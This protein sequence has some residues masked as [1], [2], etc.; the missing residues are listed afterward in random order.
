MMHIIFDRQDDVA[1]WVFEQNGD[2]FSLTSG[3]ATMGF[4][5]DNQLIAGAVYHGF[6]QCDIIIS[7]SSV[8]PKWCNKQNLYAIFAYPFEQLGCARL[9]AIVAKK[10]KRSRKLV[11]GLGF[12]RE[13]CLKKGYNGRQDAIVYGMLAENCKWL[14][15]KD[16]THERRTRAGS[17]RP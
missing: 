6:R 5:R 1:A 12:V 17:T 16:L 8:D 15:H 9:T 4:I 10:N 14:D 3:F 7:F 13:G 2:T 11:E